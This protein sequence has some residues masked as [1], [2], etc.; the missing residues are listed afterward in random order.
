MQLSDNV[1]LQQSI[2]FLLKNDGRITSTKKCFQLLGRTL[3]S[4]IAA[5]RASLRISVFNPLFF[6]DFFFAAISSVLAMS[7]SSS[8]CRRAARSL[9]TLGNLFC[10][11]NTKKKHS[12]V[13]EIYVEYRIKNQ[14]KK[15]DTVM[16]EACLASI[17]SFF[18]CS[19]Y[20]SYANGSTKCLAY[21]AKFSVTIRIRK[22]KSQVTNI[23]RFFFFCRN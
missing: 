22:L 3:S 10:I 13:Y 12:G 14:S 6:F 15:E 19:L 23:N 21:I 7:S 18:C 20:S 1:I 2:I 17:F 9:F 11:C 16:R 4:N 8:W 5:K